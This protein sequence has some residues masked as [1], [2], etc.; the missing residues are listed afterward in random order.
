MF[1]NGSLSLQLCFRNE[2]QGKG[3]LRTMQLSF[4]YFLVNQDNSIEVCVGETLFMNML[5]FM[6][7][8]AFHTGIGLHLCFFIKV[9]FVFHRFFIF[10]TMSYLELHSEKF[11]MNRNGNSILNENI[12]GLI[13]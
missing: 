11:R 6:K 2:S 8:F 3:N 13:G 10:K 7:M 1:F 9:S 4:Y 12:C 5:L